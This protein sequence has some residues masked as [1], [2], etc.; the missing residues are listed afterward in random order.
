MPF[1]FVPYAKSP[2]LDSAVIFAVLVVRL[3]QTLTLPLQRLFDAVRAVPSLIMTPPLTVD[4]YLSFRSPYSYLATKRLAAWQREYNLE[5]RLRPVLPLMVRRPDFF[6]NANP[7]LMSYV[8]KID[9][10]RVAEYLG[11]PFQWPNPDPVAVHLEDGVPTM[12]EEQPYIY[13]LT[14]LGV[15]A[16]ERGRGVDFAEQ[17]SKL[18]WTTDDWHRGYFLEE[19]TRRAGLDLA[20]MDAA[21]LHQTGRLKVEV[22]ANQV[23]LNAA[24]HWGVPTCVFDGEPF[25]GQDRLDMLLW[26]MRQ[27]RL[28]Q[29]D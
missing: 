27:K 25:F 9:S 22:D 14:Y 11:L 24:G 23:A 12:D 29:R 13:R 18:I 8:E 10:P 16:E 21:V 1:T 3:V 2:T 19:A 28:K 15:L 5:I 6:K 20:D 4:L 17:V 7:L 26:R